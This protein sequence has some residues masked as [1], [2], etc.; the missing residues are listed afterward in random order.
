ML[1]NL[2]LVHLITTVLATL[3]LLNNIAAQQATTI[4]IAAGQEDGSYYKIAQTLS[5]EQAM[6]AQ[7]DVLKTGG[8]VENIALLES[9]K[10]D[11]AFAQS[12]IALRAVRSHQPF[13]HPVANLSIV[14]PLFTEAVQPLV[15]SDL[16]LFCCL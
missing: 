10:A 9:G 6:S 3:V 14:T 4:I 2:K 16:F 12:D 1:G 5:Q 11:F 13:D 7:F 8:S 15:R